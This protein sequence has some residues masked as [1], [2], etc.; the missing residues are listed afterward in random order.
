[1]SFAWSAGAA[2]CTG[3]SDPCDT[4]TSSTIT[5]A[6]AAV[7]SEYRSAVTSSSDS[8]IAAAA[9]ADTVNGSAHAL[10]AADNLLPVPSS[11]PIAS[12]DEAAGILLSAAA[13]SAGSAAI[14]SS[15]EVGEVYTFSVQSAVC[16]AGHLLYELPV[17]GALTS[18]LF[19]TR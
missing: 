18:A 6:A 9:A 5:A 4:L 17:G 12:E 2:I 10:S 16:K 1:M 14:I 19:A 11:G 15:T 13:D 7:E 8:P 3:H